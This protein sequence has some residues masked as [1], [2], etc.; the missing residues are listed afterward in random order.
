MR[1]KTILDQKVWLGKKKVVLNIFGCKIYTTLTV[2]EI[3]D[4]FLK[5]YNVSYKK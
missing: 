5:V 4:F 3:F 1:I 2:F